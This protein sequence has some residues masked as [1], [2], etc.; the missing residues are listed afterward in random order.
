MGGQWSECG[1]A[2]GLSPA[3]Q[4]INQSTNQP[5]VLIKQQWSGHSLPSSCLTTRPCMA[6][7]P[8]P[9]LPARPPSSMALAFAKP[10]PLA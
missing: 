5:T 8:C 2:N 3:N 4:P 7:I 9:Y 6:Y 1:L 10:R